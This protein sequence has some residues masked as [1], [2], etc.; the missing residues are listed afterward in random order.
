MIRKI[1]SFFYSTKLMAILFI[2]F[3]AAMACGTFIE[4]NY[5]TDTARIW[6][7]NTWWF[8]A[9][10]LFFVVNFI[11]NI[12]RYRLLKKENWAVFI[13]HLSWVFIIVGAGITRYFGDEGTISLREG[14][15][16]NAY[17]SSRTYITV[18]VDGDY[19]GKPL[20]KR[21]Q[22]EVLFSTYTSNHY[23]WHS[24]FK[25][26]PFQVD[27]QSFAQQA[28]GMSTVVFTITSGNERQQVTVMG[29]KGL[30]HPPT[31]ISLNGLD[32]HI[33]YGAREVLLPF[34]IK[35][36]DFNIQE[37]KIVMPHLKVKY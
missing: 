23:Q 25:G 32:F 6:V 12:Q 28:E 15:T 8:E 37:L 13:L 19:Q 36:N 27:Y 35:L 17:L 9:M 20:R 24:D 7:Y 1:L 33:S 26:K 31:T 22:K 21:N 30:Q 11:G 2:A 14:E 3:A 5:D 34:S 4:S 18:L 29:H 10:I 16:A